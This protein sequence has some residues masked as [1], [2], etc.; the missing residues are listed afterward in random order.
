MCVRARPCVRVW[1]WVYVC[2]RVRDKS[3]TEGRR[4]NRQGE[5]EDGV[6][7][8]GQDVFDYFSQPLGQHE[9]EIGEAA[10]VI[11]IIVCVSCCWVLC[12]REET[13][14]NKL[15]AGVGRGEMGG[16]EREKK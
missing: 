4:T 8:G 6:G 5:R 12:V 10:I 7:G 15:R 1:V 9:S 13:D 14:R 11:C 16:G 2:A 3:E